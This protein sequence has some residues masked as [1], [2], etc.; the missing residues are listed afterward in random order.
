[1]NTAFYFELDWWAWCKSDSFALMYEE[2]TWQIKHYITLLL[3]L[4]P[5]FINQD[6]WLCILVYSMI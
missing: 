4:L 3:Y 6:S 2:Q 5:V 1:M